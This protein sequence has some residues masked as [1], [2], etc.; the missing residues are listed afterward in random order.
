MQ[1][2]ARARWR[3]LTAL[4]AI[5]VAASF[6]AFGM[7]PDAIASYYRDTLTPAAFAVWFSGL[8][9]ATLSPPILAITFW[10][11]SKRAH[12][13]WLLHLLLV[14]VTYAAV[15]GT[16]AVMMNAANEQDSDGPTGWATDPAAMMMLLCAVV[17]FAALCSARLR[18]QKAPTNGS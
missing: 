9:V 18:R 10:F 6:V 16:V 17:Y 5:A 11:G 1:K 2:S 12:Y 3:A 15:R 13:G 7:R 8:I 4:V 14:P